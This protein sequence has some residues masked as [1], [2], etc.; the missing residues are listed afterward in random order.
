MAEKLRA[1]VRIPPLTFGHE[2]YDVFVDITNLSDK[3]LDEITVTKKLVPGLIIEPKGLPEFT[4]LTKLEFRKRK[5]MQE[6]EVQ[7]GRAYEQKELR[8]APTLKRLIALT[9]KKISISFPSL[10]PFDIF[11]ILVSDET[12]S[13]VPSW[14]RQALRIEDWDDI[15]KIENV[16]FDQEAENSLLLEA[17]SI[18][19]SK[20]RKILDELE[21][22]RDTAKSIKRKDTYTLQPGETISFH[23]AGKAPFVY[24]VRDYPL[25]FTVTYRDPEHNTVGSFSLRKNITFSPSSLAIGFGA[26]VV[27]FQVLSLEEV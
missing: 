17:F 23:F 18:N 22:T 15:E 9:E 7:V 20:L 14:A 16:A 3:P 5:I 6:M 4:E 2:T 19:K 24:R 13:S 26:F 11:T 27:R 21:V 25:Q 1:S 10:I 12:N 8:T